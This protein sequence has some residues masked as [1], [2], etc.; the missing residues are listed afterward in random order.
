MPHKLILTFSE[1][2]FNQDLAISKGYKEYILLFTF[3][4]IKRLVYTEIMIILGIELRHSVGTDIP[5]FDD[6]GKQSLFLT[7]IRASSDDSGRS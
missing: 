1:S 3:I 7:E 6:R 2:L 5:D 4:Y